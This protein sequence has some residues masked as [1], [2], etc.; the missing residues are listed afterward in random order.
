[1]P[2]IR[3]T[4]VIKGDVETVGKLVRHWIKDQRRSNIVDLEYYTERRS[5]VVTFTVS[6][7]VLPAIHQSKGM[8][9]WLKIKLLYL[10]INT[11]MNL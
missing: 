5:D 8:K 11:L 4:L 1:M 6:Y 9:T 3:H 10:R 2:E 7:C